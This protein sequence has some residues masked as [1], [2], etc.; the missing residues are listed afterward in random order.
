MIGRHPFGARV[1]SQETREGRLDWR[2]AYD[3]LKMEACEVPQPL[4][5]ACIRLMD[6]LGIVFG[7]FDFVVTP[8]GQY[9]F[10]EVNEMGQFL[11]VERWTG[12]P[13][14]DAFSEFLRQGRV[15]FAWDAKRI[16]MRYA[17][18]EDEIASLVQQAATAHATLPDASIDEERIAQR[19][20]RPRTG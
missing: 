6:K 4:A 18:I 16:R 5:D 3:E 10:L 14:L 2:K 15:D 13:L 19:S 7:C 8:R 12:L 11:F 17:D 1:L 9:V 20:R